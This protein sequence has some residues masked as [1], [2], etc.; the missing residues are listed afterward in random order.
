MRDTQPNFFVGLDVGTNAVRCVV[1][2]LSASGDEPPLSV[3]GHG[4]ATNTGMPLAR[5]TRLSFSVSH[6][7]ISIFR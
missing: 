4:K 5:F 1:G 7:L 2:S 6:C 3:I